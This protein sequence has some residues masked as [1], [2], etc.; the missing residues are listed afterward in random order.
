MGNIL[1]L[2]RYA[3]TIFLC[4]LITLFAA[5]PNANTNNTLQ[6]NPQNHTTPQSNEI[7]QN[8]PP[9]N[10]SMHIKGAAVTVNVLDS[11]GGVFL[12]EP[13]QLTVYKAGTTV[14]AY[15][16]VTVTNGTAQ[17]Y[18]PK[19]HCYDLHL[20]GKKDKLAASVIENYWIR[21]EK[22]QTVTMIQR[23]VQIGALTQAPS[24]QSVTL[25]GVPF[26]DGGVWA[27]TKDQTMNLDI[28]FRSPS[29]AIQARPSDT[30]F[31]CAVGIGSAPSSRNSIAS[32]SPV[33]TRESDGSWKCV[34]RFSFDKISFQDEFNDFII[35]AY[36]VAGNRVER[37]INSIEFKER[38]PGLQTMVGARIQEFRVEM[39]RFPHSLKLFNLPEQSKIRPFG[40]TPHNGES[41]TYEVLLYF[42]IKDTASQDLPIRGFNMY[43]RIQGQS[44]WTYIGRMQYA[45]D[46]TGDQNPPP[47]L[48]SYKGTHLGYDTDPA[49]EE[50]VTYEYKVAP[51]V[52]S[53]Q[54]LDSPT[55]TA[56][57][58]PANT[59]YLENPAD[60]GK[61]KKSELNNLSFSFRITNPAIWDNR[62]AD[63][64]TFGLLITE[65]TSDQNV[66]FAGKISVYL[67][68]SA[69]NRLRLQYT[70]SGNP[71]EYSFK[72]LQ[73]RG[74]IP[75]GAVEDDFI[76][77]ANGTVTIKPA[78]L[79]NKA[80]NH[81]AFKNNT[82]Q[83]GVTY[84]WDIFDWGKD[85]K[86]PYDD[87]P[88]VFTALW[89]S[90]DANGNI[91]PPPTERLS[92]SD[93]FANGLRYAGSLNGQC[94]FKVTDE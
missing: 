23:T 2:R 27:G 54:H 82:F 5:C 52:D 89:P 38:R 58:L 35:T 66:V 42:Q 16:P 7:P 1:S 32:V 77:Y 73:K 12:L 24:I 41:N 28:V 55:A 63:F 14:I 90:K 4:A 50:W 33:C 34:A 56:C 30:N 45:A 29:R 49:L 26:Q 48:Y 11:I 59:I 69:G 39:R 19:D 94:Y 71:K 91:I 21:S 75:A 65:K 87:E 20:S 68:E 17:L 67:K 10:G 53:R 9:Q 44:E 92:S 18:L 6:N 31:G 15:G 51:F 47:G 36:D 37:H 64:F 22:A 86:S 3:A 78:Y 62:L 60:N 93:S 85:A 13:T 79:N 25:N 46:Y 88:A 72:E 83:S 81:P 40:I 57:L 74:K 8:K 70:M 84:A 76:S 80:F 43:R 61:V